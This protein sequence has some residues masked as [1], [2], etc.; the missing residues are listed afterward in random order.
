MQMVGDGVRGRHLLR[1]GLH[2]SGAGSHGGHVISYTRSGR[3]VYEPGKGHQ[4]GYTKVDHHEAASAHLEAAKKLNAAK[5]EAKTPQKLGRL[6][7]K[8]MQHLDVAQAHLDAKSQ[9]DAEE[10]AAT[11]PAPEPVAETPKVP[12]PEA[13]KPKRAVKYLSRE[14]GPDGKWVYTYPEDANKKPRKKKEVKPK[15]PIKV[16]TE[17]E[18]EAPAKDNPRE[19]A[20]AEQK[21]T[22]AQEYAFARKSKIGNKGEDL[23][24]SARHKRGEW[25]NLHDAEKNGTAAM[26][27][28]RD[29]LLAAY[30]VDFFPLLT[31]GDVSKTV[32]AMLAVKKFPGEP[33]GLGKGFVDAAGDQ[34]YETVW[35]SSLGTRSKTPGKGEYLAAK[36]YKKISEVTVKEFSEQQRKAYFDAFMAVRSSVEASAK[37]GLSTQEV[38]KGA[39]KTVLDIVM[40]RRKQN[41]GYDDD[42][43]SMLRRYHNGPL[44]SYGKTNSVYADVDSFIRFSRAPGVDAVEAAKRVLEG[45][46]VKQAFDIKGE[47]KKKGFDVNVAEMYADLA[48]R[49][50]PSVP[51]L[52]TAAKQEEALLKTMGMRGLQWG[53]TVT[54]DERK[55]HLKEAALAFHDL[56]EVTGLPQ[57]MASF[58]GR[59]GLAIGARGRKGALAH[60]E[61][62]S[63]VINL[64]RK[65]GV[66][67]LAHEWGHFFDNV[68]SEL[69]GTGAGSY[70]SS[71]YVGKDAPPVMQAMDALTKSQGW[72]DF[73]RRI[74][75]SDTYGKLSVGKR[76]YWSSDLEKFARSFERHV[77]DRLAQ[78]GRKNTYL[79]GILS[80]TNTRSDA[81]LWPNTE[82]TKQMAPLFDALFEA[83]KNSDMLKKALAMLAGEPKMRLVFNLRKGVEG[84][85]GGHVIGHTKSGKAVYSSDSPHYK[86]ISKLKGTAQQRAMNAHFKGWD[87]ADHREALDMHDAAIPGSTSA[88]KRKSKGSASF[89]AAQLHH[90]K[91]QIM[92]M[93]ETGEE[94]EHETSKSMFR[95]DVHAFYMNR[96]Q[97]KMHKSIFGEAS[98]GKSMIY[99][100]DWSDKFYG[101]PI[102]VDALKL[103]RAGMKLSGKREELEA[104]MRPYEYDAGC[105]EIDR[106]KKRQEWEQAQKPLQTEQVKLMVARSALE[107]K[108]VDWKIA[109]AERMQKIADQSSQM[110][111]SMTK[112]EGSKG[113]KVIG[114]T[115]SGKP[116]YAASS[117]HYKKLTAAFND[118]PEKGV[119]ATKKM[120]HEWSYADH[121]DA[122]SK[123]SGDFM[124]SGGRGGAA[125]DSKA[126]AKVHNEH[127]LWTKHMTK[128]MTATTLT[129]VLD[130]AMMIVEDALSADDRLLPTSIDGAEESTYKENPAPSFRV[131]VLGDSALTFKETMAVVKS[132][133]QLPEEARKNLL[134]EAG[135]RLHGPRQVDFKKSRVSVAEFADMVGTTED[136]VRRL[137][138]RCGDA[139]H[140]AKMI[141]SKMPDIQ[142]AHGLTDED[143]EALFQASM[144]TLKSLNHEQWH[145]WMSKSFANVAVTDQGLA[146]AIKTNGLMHRNQ[147]TAEGFAIYGGPEEVTPGA[148]AQL[149]RPEPISQRLE[150]V[151]LTALNL[152]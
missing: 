121:E 86:A 45:K 101:S 53:N 5:V 19:Q 116:V 77:Y 92:R 102:Y 38:L 18:Q 139:D 110:G 16:V 93:G 75:M 85:K 83:F 27:V 95:A 40:A 141:K 46:T 54:D 6:R 3:A 7:S 29:N 119:A 143:A 127:L 112:S 74:A 133:A 11:P 24:N 36:G 32:A 79:S 31:P 26:M 48:E 146:E 100:S 22:E 129:S 105:S 88:E 118:S 67:T 58:N 59:L 81:E 50:G 33:P 12:E 13:P 65:G 152:R 124:S 84:S 126:A 135:V 98:I 104:T 8:I 131:D 107:L 44:A 52:A 14:K 78:N 39:R 94:P 30:P 117:G 82:E 89:K 122:A 150:I 108:Y 28:K 103:T 130:N 91:R 55:H 87:S 56:A 71:V 128:S 47:A 137:A 99:G 21:A 4:I 68:L 60:Y 147:V 114:H 96:H 63:R 134:Q 145:H 113:G 20:E 57:K 109:Q 140:F 80:D 132:V 136:T 72:K 149:P 144:R 151:P 106:I 125:D 148:R 97:Q 123:H 62:E 41:G 90:T 43:N 64:T 111:K 15:L 142:R 76:Q 115:K 17:D 70:L 42:T 9:M 35:E 37:A 23:K 49:I 34:I 138:R 10:A 69:S 66:G 2:A 51:E 61:T 73:S 120:H 25:T 1:K